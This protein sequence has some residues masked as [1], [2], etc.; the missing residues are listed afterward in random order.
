VSGTSPVTLRFTGGGLTPAVTAP[1]T[2]TAP[3]PLNLTIDNVH[4]NQ[5]TQS[6]DGSVPIVAGRAALA[7]VFVKSNLQSNTATPSVRLRTFVNG[8]LFRTYSIA[9]PRSS[10]PKV[11]DEG[12]LTSSWNVVIPAEEV[13]AGMAVLADVDPT[14]AVVESSDADNSFPA[15]GTPLALNVRQV[16]TMKVTFIPVTQPG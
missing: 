5:A 2:P 10:V 6:Y 7:R 4:L 8:T 9:A 15:S 1:F 11:M 3:P 14:N 13:V 12:T 16:P